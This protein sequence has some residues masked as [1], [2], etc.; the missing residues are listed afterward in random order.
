[1]SP[2]PI[3]STIHQ[4]YHL[5]YLKT[6]ESTGKKREIFGTLSS[7]ISQHT[8]AFTMLSCPRSPQNNDTRLSFKRNRT[9]QRVDPGL[10]SLA[11]V[12]LWRATRRSQHEHMN[13]W[14]H[15]HMKTPT[16]GAGHMVTVEPA[17]CF[18]WMSW[19][20]EHVWHKRIA[21]WRNDGWRRKG[22]EREACY[23]IRWG[24]LRAGWL[25][26][27]RLLVRL[28]WAS[29]LTLTAPEELAVAWCDL[30][31]RRCVKSGL[32]IWTILEWRRFG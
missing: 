2:F 1:M 13:T 32:W 14:T 18:Y 12:H 20:L 24:G 31:R 27:G 11:D 22:R 28:P 10:Q 8:L 16:R 29:H 26:T 5:G 7:N 17:V 30:H 9:Y 23:K 4:L 25:V 3:Q 19:G 21:T 15:E 6:T